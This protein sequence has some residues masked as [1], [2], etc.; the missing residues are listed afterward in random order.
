[1]FAEIDALL[2]ARTDG[3]FEATR[4]L[5]TQFLIELD[6]IKNNKNDIVVLVCMLLLRSILHRSLT[7]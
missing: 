3:E 2:S 7:I 6:G 4:R 1:M 5:K